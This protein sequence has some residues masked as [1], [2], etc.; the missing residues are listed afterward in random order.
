M[1]KFTDIVV[2]LFTMIL[3]YGAIYFCISLFY[4]DLDIRV[5]S[6]W[7]R[8]IGFIFAYSATNKAVGQIRKA[9]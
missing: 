9:I 1:D 3:I 2:T 6:G 7:A 8:V 5:W 4:W